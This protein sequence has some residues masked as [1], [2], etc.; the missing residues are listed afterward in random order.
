MKRGNLKLTKYFRYKMQQNEVIK[1]EIE[2]L[3]LQESEISDLISD[4]ENRINEVDPLKYYFLLLS[5]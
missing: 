3:K 2:Q 5:L 4:L 1:I